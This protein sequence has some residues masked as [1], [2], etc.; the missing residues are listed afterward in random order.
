MLKRIL[1]LVCLLGLLLSP[2]AAAPV[3]AQAGWEPG[4]YTGWVYVT[5]RLS[6]DHSIN[7]QGATLKQDTVVYW[8]A[9][10]DL[11]VKAEAGDQGWVHV[12]LPFEITGQETGFFTMPNASCNFNMLGLGQSVVQDLA[13]LT[14][15]P[16][17][18]GFKLPLV[19]PGTT[20]QV[21]RNSATGQC[22]NMAQSALFLQ[23]TLKNTTSKIS[24]IAFKVAYTSPLSIGGTCELTDWDTSTAIQFGS[25]TRE[26]VECFWR[27]FREP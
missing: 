3:R 27:V 19:V 17:G 25:L 21:A 14:S 13:Q 26:N 22:G 7:Q 4:T 1:L 24:G 20:A 6:K 11:S 5:A 12:Y 23:D 15:M 8:Q 2:G 18:A 9:H 10:G 16:I